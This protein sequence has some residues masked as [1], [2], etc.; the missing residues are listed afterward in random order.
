MNFANINFFMHEALAN[1]RRAGLMT[2]ITVSTIAVALLMMGGFLLATMNMESFMARLQDEAMVTLF[3][4]P[5]TLQREAGSTRM[6]VLGMP[7]V[8]K[9]QVIGP[10]QAAK[11]LFSDPQDRKIIDLALEGGKNP[12]PITLRLKL[13]SGNDLE[14]LLA[15]VKRLPNVESVSYGKE[16]FKQFQG[17]SDLLWLGSLLVIILLGLSSLFIVFNTVRLTL[18][19]RREEIVIMKLVGAT[20]W[21]IRWPFIIEGFI[22][23]LL[24]AVLALLLL[25]GTYRFMLA[26]LGGMI[27]FF[28]FDMDSVNLLKLSLKL[29]MMG[30]VLGI[31]GSLLSLRDLHAFTRS[32]ASKDGG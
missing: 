26:R 14:P 18:F 22:Q 13:R 24:G 29:L 2:F 9:V 3:L 8:T 30:I 28:H 7:E 19:M 20:N 4:R 17:L 5:G 1:C 6:Q 16:A 12:L 23:G 32:S 11:E 15:K 21:F 10:E 31:S 27:P 25:L